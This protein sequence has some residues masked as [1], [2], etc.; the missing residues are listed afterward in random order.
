MDVLG[1]R[2]H[3]RRFL[4]FLYARKYQIRS[5]MWK[6]KL[7]TEFDEKGSIRRSRAIRKKDYQWITVQVGDTIF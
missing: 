1:G 2:I 3:L 4:S 5:G 6:N 7:A